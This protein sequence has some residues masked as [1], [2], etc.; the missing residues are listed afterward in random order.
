MAAHKRRATNKTILV[1]VE[2]YTEEALLKHIKALYLGLACGISVTVKNARGHGPQGVADAMSSA[3][4]IASF[5]YK[6]ALLDSDIPIC[7]KNEVFFAS[8]KVELFL[9]VPAIEATLIELVGGKVRQN[10]NTAECKQVLTRLLVGDSCEQR[11]YER[12]FTKPIIEAG[13]NNNILMDNLLNYIVD[14]LGYPKLRRAR[15]K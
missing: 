12:H 8:Q 2:G 13:R 4:K 1:V 6:S 7:K 10:A 5:D 15:G 3:C 9:S 11:Y 14:P